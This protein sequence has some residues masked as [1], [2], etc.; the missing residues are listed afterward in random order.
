M[1]KNTVVNVSGDRD[2]GTIKVRLLQPT[3]QPKD[4]KDYDG[5]PKQQFWIVEVIENLDN[6]YGYLPGE[7]GI[8]MKGETSRKSIWGQFDAFYFSE[9]CSEKQKQNFL[10]KRLA[11]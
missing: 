9:N 10:R 2:V 4:W 3:T 7:L 8:V 11:K 6:S 5:D 1:L